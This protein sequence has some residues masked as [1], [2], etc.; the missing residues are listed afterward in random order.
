MYICIYNNS[1]LSVRSKLGPETL[2]QWSDPGIPLEKIPNS[3]PGTASEEINHLNVEAR[4]QLFPHLNHY[5]FLAACAMFILESTAI[6]DA[7]WPRLQLGMNPDA[8]PYG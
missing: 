4:A 3:S 1:G 2:L 7:I 5:S 6:R 8:E